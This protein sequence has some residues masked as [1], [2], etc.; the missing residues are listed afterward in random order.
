MSLERRLTSKTKIFCVI[1]YPIEHSMSPIMWNPALKELNLDF[2][3]VAFSVHPKNLE[4]AIEGMKV[5]GIKGMNVTLPYKQEIMKY[6]DEIDPIA[7]KI[8]AVNTIKNDEGIL[9]AKNTDAGGAKKSL[10]ENGCEVEGK[11]VL[12]LGSGG[13]ARSITYILAED[14]NKIVVTDLIEEKALLIANEIKELMGVNIEGKISSEKNIE[15]AIKN[16]DI[17]INATPVGMSP[18]VDATPVS[19]D[20]LHPDLFVFDVV[21]NPLTTR[22]MREAARVGC[23]TLGG[24]DMLINQGVLAFEWWTNKKPNKELMKKKIIEYLGL[25]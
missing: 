9:K 10:L 21:Y 3:Y 14:A 13:V 23:K 20:L 2:I 1:G 6:I 11:N 19:M 16:S 5:M 18:N 7:Q 4:K 12:I 25:V 15:I 24:L 8:G 17:L 22:L